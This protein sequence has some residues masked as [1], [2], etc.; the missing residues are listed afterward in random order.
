M[1]NFIHRLKIEILLDIV[2]TTT[3]AN[4]NVIVNMTRDDEAYYCVTVF[5]TVLHFNN[6]TYIYDVIHNVMRES[7]HFHN[8]SC[9]QKIC[10]ADEMNIVDKMLEQHVDGIVFEWTTNE[11]IISYVYESEPFIHA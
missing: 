8:V 5:S 2:N 3:L 1:D 10:L 9:E 11:T 7:E 6:A 4:G